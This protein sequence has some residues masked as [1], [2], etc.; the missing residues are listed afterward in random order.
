MK[1]IAVLAITKNGNELFTNYFFAEDEL[2][3]EVIHDNDIIK[4]SGERRYTLDSL[5][6]TPNIPIT[7][8]GN[9]FEPNSTYKFDIG[10][11]T[12]H[13]SENFIVLNGFNAEISP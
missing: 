3:I 6:A 13:N 10:L 4:I 1:K 7:I 9:F 11:R 8:S 2:L 12:I 5:T